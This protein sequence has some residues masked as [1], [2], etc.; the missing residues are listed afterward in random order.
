MKE[1]R[2]GPQTNNTGIRSDRDGIEED[3]NGT[4]GDRGGIHVDSQRNYGRQFR[5]DSRQS[6]MRT[7]ELFQDSEPEGLGVATRRACP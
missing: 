5:T 1:N 7:M 6:R 2:D 3:R 4:L